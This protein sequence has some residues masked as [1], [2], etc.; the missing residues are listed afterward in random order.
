[1]RLYSVQKCDSH[2]IDLSTSFTIHLYSYI[3]H[4]Y[5]INLQFRSRHLAHNVIAKSRIPS[6]Y[7]LC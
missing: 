7:H 3:L 4:T 1:M 2:N 6:Q 5:L